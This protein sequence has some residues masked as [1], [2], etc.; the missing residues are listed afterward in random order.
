MQR[1]PYQKLFVWQK[2]IALVQEVYA[3]ARLLPAEER[4][5]LSDQLRRAAVSIPSNI[6]EGQGRQ[7]E[8]E[9]KQF[10]AIARGSVYEVETQLYICIKTGYLTA[11]QTKNA[12]SL[13]KEVG[14]MLNKMISLTSDL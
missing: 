14:R 8:K 12:F 6:A 3:L 11:D 1:M 10:L 13:C 5:A 7:T 9:L 4:Y 2:G